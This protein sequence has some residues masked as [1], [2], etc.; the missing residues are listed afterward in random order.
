MHT[1]CALL[2]VDA[3]HTISGVADVTRA[4][5]GASR[6]GANAVQV[7]RVCLKVAFVLILANNSISRVASI[8]VATVGPNNVAAV[9]L[10]GTCVST[11]L[12]LVDVIALRAVLTEIARVTGAEERANSVAA[13]GGVR[14]GV[15]VVVALVDVGAT[16]P[17]TSVSGVAGARVRPVGVGARGGRGTLVKTLAAFINIRAG[18][19]VAGVAGVAMA[20]ERAARVAARTMHHVASVSV[21]ALI[22]VITS[23][24]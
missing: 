9:S 5:E 4:L 16:E 22:D 21:G 7:A 11:E 18:L 14:A 24:S 23:F 10:A 19:T 2:D 15:Q 13:F 12:A 6:V 8:A 1:S 3:L 20:D 17:V